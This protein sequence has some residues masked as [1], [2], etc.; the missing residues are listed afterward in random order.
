MKEDEDTKTDVKF[1]FNV[2]LTEG[3]VLKGRNA[4]ICLFSRRNSEKVSHIFADFEHR[5]TGEHRNFYFDI[6]LTDILK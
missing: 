1:D 3:G 4:E 5:N 2:D 6:Y